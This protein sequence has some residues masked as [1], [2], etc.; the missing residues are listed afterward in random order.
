MRPLVLILLLLASG[1][2]L[3]AQEQ[4]RKLIDRIL[5]PDYSLG[6]P[7]QDKTFNSGGAGGLDTT[8]NATVKD[9]YFVQKFSSKTYQTKDYA[10]K[11]YWQGDF[12]FATKA[13][14]VKSD[15]AANKIF[16]TKAAAV[17]DAHEAGK[18]YTNAARGYSTR[19]ADEKGKTSQ[20]HL[21]SEYL[22]QGQM[23][24]DQVRDLLNKSH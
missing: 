9:F 17:K 6:N 2:V 16:E 24:M 21:D 18:D 7:M 12:Q 10:A 5:Q 19:E 14:A 15:N 1:G 20:N 3:R 22:P 4:E 23:N 11:G 8:K 13:A